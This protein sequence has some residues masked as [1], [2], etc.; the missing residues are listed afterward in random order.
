MPAPTPP[1]HP[2]YRGAV[3]WREPVLWDREPEI[4]AV[5]AFLAGPPGGVLWV[6]G[7][8]G[9]GKRSLVAHVLGQTRWP[10]CADGLI[11]ID[12]DGVAWRQNL[13]EVAVRWQADR[14]PAPLPRLRDHWAAADIVV[15]L[16]GASAAAWTAGQLPVGGGC[17]RTVVVSADAPPAEGMATLPIGGWRD[18]PAL[19]PWWAGPA[20]V[21]ATWRSALRDAGDLPW[22]AAVLAAQLRSLHEQEGPAGLSRCADALHAAPPGG[23]GDALLSWCWKRLGDAA[24]SALHLLV[25]QGGDDRDGW[26]AQLLGHDALGEASVELGQSG[27]IQVRSCADRPFAAA[28]VCAFVRDQ[29]GHGAARGRLVHAVALALVRGLETPALADPI[30]RALRA[31]A[32]VLDD[33][34][35]RGDAGLLCALFDAWSA[36]LVAS[37]RAWELNDAGQRAVQEGDPAVAASA[38]RALGLACLAEG[39]PE[40]AEAWLVAARQG[41]RRDLALHAPAQRSC[42]S[43]YADPAVCPDPALDAWLAELPA[44][45]ELPSARAEQAL[46]REIARHFPP[47]TVG[48][49]RAV[50]DAEVAVAHSH[51][52]VPGAW[53]ALVRAHPAVSALPRRDEQAYHLVAMGQVAARAGQLV[54]AEDAFAAA[55]A[56]FRA[57]GDWHSE[58]PCRH[59]QWLVVAATDKARA[60]VL[61]G[62]IEAL[63]QQIAAIGDPHAVRQSVAVCLRAARACR[64]RGEQPQART[65][66][67]QAAA[68]CRKLHLRDED[69]PLAEALRMLAELADG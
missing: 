68:G 51:A 47:W 19:D 37:G 28:P 63:G 23:G 44:Q 42:A 18:P 46:V 32:V 66:L 69:P 56:R 16:A 1:T 59:W 20:A 26:A 6:W 3:I 41:T 54:D 29:P 61:R 60:A 5:A 31:V 53:Q 9:S 50:V 49:W 36:P 10:A 4:A 64:Q 43:R 33:G 65:W 25:A 8:A 62:Q 2:S 35:A 14:D 67:E 27:L 30:Q 13:R 52:D 48:E 38:Q 11:W 58:Q 12:L 15:V 55:A 24:R 39:Q 21:S 45:A 17:A 22:M 57:A 40:L 34:L 7:P